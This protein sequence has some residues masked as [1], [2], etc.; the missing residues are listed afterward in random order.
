MSVSDVEDFTADAEETMSL[1]EELKSWK[2]SLVEE[3]AA[4]C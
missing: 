2:R 4:T 1:M 3:V